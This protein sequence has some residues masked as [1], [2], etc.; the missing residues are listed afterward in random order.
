[1]FDGSTWHDEDSPTS[2]I[3]IAKGLIIWLR[4]NV[5][6][7]PE[8]CYLLQH[9][10]VKLELLDQVYCEHSIES[11]LAAARA[12][13]FY[14]PQNGSQKRPEQVQWATCIAG[15]GKKIDKGILVI[16]AMGVVT[17]LP[18]LADV[19]TPPAG[20][21]QRRWD[22][23]GVQAVVDLACM[24]DAMNNLGGHSKKINPLLRI[25][26]C[27]N[28]S[29]LFSSVGALLWRRGVL[30][31]MLTNKGWVDGNGSNSGGGF[32]KPRGGRET[33][34]GGD[35]LEGPCGGA[36]WVGVGDSLGDDE[37]V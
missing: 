35:G 30:L 11:T 36:T 1:M 3:G 26:K 22:F 4:Q 7:L 8:C 6:L 28:F 17:P 29:I 32:G 27:T 21:A 25:A 20:V 33:R 12:D 23:T 34:G 18:A 5:H 37:E 24:H 9:V 2:V 16:R 13:N 14:Y 10:L 19:T 15:E 31:L